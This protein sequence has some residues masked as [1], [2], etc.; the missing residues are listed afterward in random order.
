MVLSKVVFK[1]SIT[2]KLECGEI[3]QKDPFVCELRTLSRVC[4]LLGINSVVR[5]FTSG[6]F[7]VI[8]PVYALTEDI[9]DQNL[10]K[11][12]LL[13][14]IE[15]IDGVNMKLLLPYGGSNP[16]GEET[17][18]DGYRFQCIFLLSRGEVQ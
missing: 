18:P 6:D 13:F 17:L 5:R 16:G 8:F 14:G 4:D 12:Q 2:S 7:V 10:T 11:G 1:T 3:V 9:L 15:E